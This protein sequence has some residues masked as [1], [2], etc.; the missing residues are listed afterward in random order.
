MADQNDNCEERF[1]EIE[2]TYSSELGAA[3]QDERLSSEAPIP[4]GIKWLRE[5][6]IPIAGV[7]VLVLFICLVQHYSTRTINWTNT[8]DFTDAFRN[9]AQALALITAG[10]W[11][12]F[13]FIK[14][15]TF[16]ES[17]I[18][19]VSGRFAAID[20]SIYL[21]VTTQIKNV[22]LTE[23]EFSQTGSALIVFQYVPA[24]VSEIHAVGDERLTSFDVFDDKGRSIE[25]NEMVEEQTLIALPNSVQLAYR[26]E[27]E[28]LSISGNTWRATHIVDKSTLRDNASVEQL[29]G[30]R[31]SI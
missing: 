22:G 11:A 25:P 19:V 31:E 27:L 23:I 14:G 29:R 24:M 7:L 12:Y 21:I 1:P 20:G 18:P 3:T 30:N 15:R 8:K 16:Q 10:I 6:T 4:D 2:Q 28:I 13:K 9:L 17:L 5:H 26:L